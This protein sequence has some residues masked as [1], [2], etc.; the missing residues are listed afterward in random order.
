MLVYNNRHAMMDNLKLICGASH[1]LEYVHE[2]YSQCLVYYTYPLFPVINGP[3]TELLY[4]ATE[5]AQ[6]KINKYIYI[7]ISVQRNQ[8]DDGPF[9]RFFQRNTYSLVYSK[10]C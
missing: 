1:C 3:I 4:F 10:H 7:N 8:A 9:L 5:A 6:H 2:T